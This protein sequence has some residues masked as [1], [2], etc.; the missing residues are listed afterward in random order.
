MTATASP[1]RFPLRRTHVETAIRQSV[2]GF[3]ID[4]QER[5][6][7]SEAATLTMAGAVAYVSGPLTELEFDVH[8]M[9]SKLFLEQGCPASNTVEFSLKRLARERWADHNSDGR[10]SIAAALDKLVDGSITIHDVDPYTGKSEPGQIW[11]LTLL[12]GAGGLGDYARMVE[13]ISRG[14]RAALAACGSLSGNATYQAVLPTWLAN[15]LREGNGLA[16]N[17]DVQFR[18][19]GAAKTTWVQLEGLP[20]VEI[21][22][23]DLE[24]AEVDLSLETI[25][26]FGLRHATATDGRKYLKASVIGRILAGDPTYRELEIV[27]HPTRK[28]GTRLRVVRATGEERQRLLREDARQ[29]SERRAA[30]AEAKRTRRAAAQQQ[31]GLDTGMGEDA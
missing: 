17:A 24:V 13:A 6:L 28:R 25:R 3:Q 5:F 15:S 26:A 8:T 19:N 7:R 18:L 9:L 10:H 31:L 14:E 2:G 27:P 12:E 4:V 20:Y 22:G 30:R 11:R 16:L 21:A 29:Q 23:E 1:A